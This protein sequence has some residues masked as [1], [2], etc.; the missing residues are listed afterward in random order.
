M[1]VSVLARAHAELS[2]ERA[3]HAYGIS[4]ARLRGERL[5]GQ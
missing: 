1:E 3:L 4:E 5:Q 2:L